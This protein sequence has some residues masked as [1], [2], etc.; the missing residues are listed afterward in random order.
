M[1]D[2]EYHHKDKSVYF[3]IDSTALFEICKEQLK[4]K[5]L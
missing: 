2:V 5:V 3:I 1:N 4:K